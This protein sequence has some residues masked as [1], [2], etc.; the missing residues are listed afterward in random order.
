MRVEQL[1]VKR[2]SFCR[3]NQNLG[4]VAE[5]LWTTRRGSL[6]VLDENGNVASIITDRDL[7][8]ALGTRNVRAGDVRVAEVVLPRVF[9]CRAADDA[10][11]ALETMV[12]Q[13]VRRL[14]V[15]DAFDKLEGIVSIDDYIRRAA[16]R[17]PGEEKLHDAVMRAVKRICDS[18]EPGVWHEPTEMLTVTA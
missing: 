10:V 8:I 13:N 6:P 3:M 2:V 4:E 1:M 9:T 15:V 14:P 5:I 17:L 18:R 11:N 12:A 16:L 7:C